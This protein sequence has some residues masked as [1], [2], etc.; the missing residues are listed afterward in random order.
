MATVEACVQDLP[1]STIDSRVALYVLPLVTCEGG[2]RGPPTRQTENPS[3]TLLLRRPPLLQSRCRR[4]RDY[5]S[6]WLLHD[7]FVVRWRPSSSDDETSS[8][9]ESSV[10]PPHSE[11]GE[12]AV[13]V[14]VPALATDDCSHSVVG[15][16]SRS[17]SFVDGSAS[18]GVILGLSRYT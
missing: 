4:G 18:L 8:L 5:L 7:L 17:V 3:L 16:V 12:L 11:A 2:Q 14:R 6:T 15:G 13:S 10:I 1:L 9:A